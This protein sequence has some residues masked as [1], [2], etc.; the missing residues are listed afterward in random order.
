[1][2][3]G[4]HPVKYLTL[5]GSE[6]NIEIAKTRRFPQDTQSVAGR[7]RQ[8]NICSIRRTGTPQVL[9][10]FRGCSTHIL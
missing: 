5:P 1:M 6:L 2:L 7:I 10:E 9:P 3:E 4:L 8:I